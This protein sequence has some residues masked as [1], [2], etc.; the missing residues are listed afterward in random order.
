MPKETFCRE[1]AVVSAGKEG[2]SSRQCDV[3]QCQI[4]ERDPKGMRAFSWFSKNILVFAQVH[5][6]DSTKLG[7]NAAAALQRKNRTKWTAQHFIGCFFNLTTE[8]GR[9]E[10]GKSFDSLSFLHG[11]ERARDYYLESLDHYSEIMSNIDNQRRKTIEKMMKCLH[12]N[13]RLNSGR[14]RDDWNATCQQ[15]KQES[16]RRRPIVHSVKKAASSGWNGAPR[17]KVEP[18]MLLFAESILKNGRSSRDID[19]VLEELESLVAFM[20]Q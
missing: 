8:S 1:R 17:K 16:I 13:L 15:L 14:T 11:E 5:L 2:E 19:S 3:H 12:S 20:K 4:Q 6:C 10:A 7:G 9:W 18:D